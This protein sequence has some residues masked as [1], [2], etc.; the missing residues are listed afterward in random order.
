[1]RR[2]TTAPITPP[3]PSMPTTMI[4]VATYAYG[5]RQEIERRVFA[6]QREHSRYVAM[7]RELDHIFGGELIAV[8][9]D[10][11]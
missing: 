3:M 11:D 7:I 9:V 4:E 5:L 8:S 6:L 2:K 1:M 10:D